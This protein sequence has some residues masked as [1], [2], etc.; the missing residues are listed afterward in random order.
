MAEENKQ[1]PVQETDELKDYRNEDGTFNEDKLKQAMTEKKYYR[2]QISKLRNMP[3][4]VEE[5]GENFALDSKFDEFV[6]D[7][8]NKEKID[9]VFSKLDALCFDKGINVERNHDIRRFLLDEMVESGAVDLTPKADK[10]A[11]AKADHEA[12]LKELQ[13]GIGDSTNLDAWQES[14]LGWLKTFANS[15]PEYSMYENIVKNSANGALSMNKIR[16]AMMGNRIPIVNSDPTYNEEEWQ[17]EF[18]KA[19]RDTQNKML[20][21]RAKKLTKKL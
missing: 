3:A 7:E 10:E 20:E 14:L 19:D 9:K 1:P 8:K 17:R 16:Q 15:E 11:K 12:Y 6:S 5:Y 2:Q 21:E 4:K 13:D 18:N